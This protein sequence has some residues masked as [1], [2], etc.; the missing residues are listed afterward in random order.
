[1]FCSLFDLGPYSYQRQGHPADPHGIAG[2][3]NGLIHSFFRPSDD[4]QQFPYLIPSQFFAYQVLNDLIKL[5]KEFKWPDDIIQDASKLISDL[6]PI[7]FDKKLSE[8][9]ANIITQK[10]PK[11]GLMFAYEIDGFG[12]QNL[13][14]D[15][16]IPSLLSL[17]YLCPDYIPLNHTIY[18]NTRKFILS[19]DNPWFFRGSVIEGQ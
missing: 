13:M 14:D 19:T 2:K 18:Q 10:H 7:L 15:S 5:A 16:N 3:P 8:N 17:P 9:E 6:D 11:Y 12:H 1:M 4:L